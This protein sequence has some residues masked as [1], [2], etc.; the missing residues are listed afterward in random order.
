MKTNLIFRIVVVVIFCLMFNSN[1]YS[2]IVITKDELPSTLGTTWKTLNDTTENVTVDVGT[3]GEN[4]R[5]DF[6]QSI[7]G[8]EIKQIVVS[9][10]STPYRSDFSESNFVIKY[11]GGL[12]DLIYS[13]VFPQIKGDVYFYQKITDTAVYLVGTGF[14]SSFI[15]GSAHFEPPNAILNFI[16]TKYGDAWTT[17]SV[18]TIVKDTTIMG[19][20]GQLKLTVNDSAYSIIDAWGKI[21]IPLGE[22]DCLRMKS[23]VTM[24]EEITF[25]DRPITTKRAR[26]INYNWITE[27]YGIV[28]RIASHTDEQDDNFTDA[29]L[30]SRMTSFTKIEDYLP[31][32]WNFTANTNNNATVVL[33]VIANPNIIDTP[34]A[35]G[36]YI[37]VFTP[38]GLC[39]GWSCWQGQNM[40]I[41]VWG[42]DDQ[43]PERDGFLAG[44]ILNYRVYQTNEQKEWTSVEVSYLE[45]TGFYSQ[46]AIMIL[47]KFNVYEAKTITLNINKGWN[48]FSINVN[49][50]EP[51]IATVMSPIVDKLVIVKNGAGN[52]YI[53]QYS[54]NTIGN[55]NFKEG[56]HGYLEE[57]TSLEITGHPVDPSTP[58]ELKAGWSMISYLP[59]L[60]MN[61]AIAFASISSQLVIAKDGA[62]QAYIPAYS[63]NQIG[64]TLPGQGYQIYLD[65]AGTLT[66]PS[67][68]GHLTEDKSDGKT[69]QNH[70]QKTYTEHFQF[71]ANT[72]ENATVVVT[73]DIEPKYS[74]DTPL[75]KGD[76]IGIF[77]TTDLCCGAIVW[78]GVNTAITVW[79]DDSQ[80]NS[81][82]GFQAGDTLRFR[83]WKKSVNVEFLVSV[84]YRQGDPRVYQANAFSVLTELIAELATN[85]T[86]KGEPV[87]PLDFNL[88]QNYPNPFNPTTSISYQLYK[89]GKVSLKVFNLMG[90]EIKTLVNEMKKIGTHNVLWNGEDNLGK[91]APSGIYIYRLEFI[92]DSKITNNNI[93][94]IRKMIFLK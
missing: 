43:T 56:Y 16:P 90:H 55:I 81:R 94:R 6:T 65:K 29:R 7:N 49:P 45:G 76:E 8:I 25:N 88:L 75:E 36:D 5:W 23:Y 91:K 13:D 4:R 51:N 89:D 84:S 63:I 42:D 40:A 35:S 15:S 58:I 61:A 80:T 50:S 38:A 1:I 77:T 34:L 28:M 37:G 31:D 59:D 62:G 26:I 19:I 14:R 66:Y 39:C 18:F 67:G 64:K 17:K 21:V 74:N 53:P 72:G 12:L 54:I 46:N 86:E 20:S 82:D 85:V 33:P 57:V 9:L 10:D 32:H 3:T 70:L 44:E 48:I 41:T 27:N 60:P 47:N 71:T 30:C 68:R 2:Q 24:N 73:A 11:E 93:T 87:I 22:F 83:V 69:K 92:D 78:E 79:G 52:T